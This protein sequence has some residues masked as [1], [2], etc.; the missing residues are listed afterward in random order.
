[1]AE[2]KRERGNEK[3]NERKKNDLEMKSEQEEKKK[4]KIAE[5]EK[6]EGK[7]RKWRKNDWEVISEQEGKEK[8]M[9]REKKQNGERKRKQKEKLKKKIIFRHKNQFKCIKVF[10]KIFTSYKQINSMSVS[11][12]SMSL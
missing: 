8:E 5:K 12:Y 4:D 6:S 3:V 11:L 7:M 9:K 2:G 10:I 1:M